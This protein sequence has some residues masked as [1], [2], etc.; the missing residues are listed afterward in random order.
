MLKKDK[1]TASENRSFTKKSEPLS[2]DVKG[3]GRENNSKKSKKQE[4]GSYQE[5]R[6]SVLPSMP[7]G[8]TVGN[9]FIDGK[10]GKEQ[11]RQRQRRQR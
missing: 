5:N 7:K 11:R 1:S 3:G 4:K 10:E 6:G 2:I 9:I 8:E